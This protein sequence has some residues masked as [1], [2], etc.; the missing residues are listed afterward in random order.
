MNGRKSNLAVVCIA[1]TASFVVVLS[2]FVF[3]PATNSGVSSAPSIIEVGLP[4]L[5]FPG[6]YVGVSVRAPS[7]PSAPDSWSVSYTYPNDTVVHVEV[8]STAVQNS[9]WQFQIPEDAPAG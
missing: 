5:V 3:H 4:K 7:L 8:A 2:L 6:Q 9:M 1:L